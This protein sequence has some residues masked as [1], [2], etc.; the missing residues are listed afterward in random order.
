LK[1]KM[2]MYDG[3]AMLHCVRIQDGKAT[4]YG[5]TYI[6]SPRF[7]ANEAAGKELY[8]TFGDLAQGGLPVAKKMGL[9]AMKMK[10]GAIPTL[11]GSA[12]TVH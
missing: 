8:A 3:D 5:N 1:G 2:H 11:K 6:R 4:A 12:A 10:S 7:V 9:Q